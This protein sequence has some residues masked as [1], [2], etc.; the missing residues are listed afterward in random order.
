MNQ[1]VDQDDGCQFTSL[2]VLKTAPFDIHVI[3]QVV[4]S[5]VIMP[6]RAGFQ[7]PSRATTAFVW[8]DV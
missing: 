2:D 8:A 7:V 6:P 3:H 4:G 5:L 1:E